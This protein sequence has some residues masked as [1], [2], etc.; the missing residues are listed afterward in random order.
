MTFFP[1]KTPV[2]FEYLGL[3][4]ENVENRRQEGWKE[5]KQNIGMTLP[6]GLTLQR[7]R[8]RIIRAGNHRL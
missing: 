6:W 7:V 2:Y 4:S 5:K 3:K 1:G 8:W